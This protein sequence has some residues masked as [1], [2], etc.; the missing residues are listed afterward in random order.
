MRG[1]GVWARRDGSG[2]AGVELHALQ[3][4]TTATHSKLVTALIAAGKFNW[5]A[6]GGGDG[7]GGGVS[8]SNCANFMRASCAP[9]KQQVPMMMAAGDAAN[10]S[11]A[12]FLITRPPIG[13]IGWGWESDDRKWN[14]VFLLQPGAP[15][16]LCRETSP[17]VFARQ[18]TAGVA[19]LDCN[20][21]TASLPF[22]ALQ[23]P[24]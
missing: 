3:L 10:Q 22:P 1:V 8:H 13:F 17:G 20:S 2:E 23:T 16:G 11:I 21:Y 5:Q 6:F 14:D 9:G 4:A 24:T 15:E 19:K 18:W 12:A 7:T